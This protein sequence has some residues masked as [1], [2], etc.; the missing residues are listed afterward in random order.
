M[1][2]CSKTIQEIWD[3]MGSETPINRARR[4][5]A[6]EC[7]KIEQAGMQGHKLSV[8]EQRRMEFDA[9]QKIAAEL[10]VEL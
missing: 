9:V 5:F 7:A 6:S 1:A 10:G 2:H 4:V 8:F 3:L